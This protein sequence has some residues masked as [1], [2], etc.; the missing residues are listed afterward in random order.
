MTERL[1]DEM[2]TELVEHLAGGFLQHRLG[3]HGRAGTEIV[4]A[5]DVYPTLNEAIVPAA[6]T[7]A[8]ER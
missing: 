2:P 7:M 8:S 5:H 1:G 4:D 6:P 3:K